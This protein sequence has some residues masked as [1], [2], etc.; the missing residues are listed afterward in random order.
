MKKFLA[1]LILCVSCTFAI[2]IIPVYAEDGITVNYEGSTVSFDAEPFLENGITMI[3]MRA[4]AEKMGAEV[5]WSPSTKITTIKRGQD[6]LEIPVGGT[7]AK[8]NGQDILLDMPAKVVN[9]RVF[10]PLR[11]VGEQLG[12]NVVWDKETKIIALTEKAEV[13]KKSTTTQYTSKNKN[14]SIILPS[15]NW[16]EEYSDLENTIIAD[17]TEGELS[18]LISSFDKQELKLSGIQTAE[19]FAKFN[20]DS[21]YYTV[22]AMGKVIEQHITLNNMNVVTADEI[23]VEE[24][25]TISKAFF[26][27]GE[28]E[29]S[30]YVCAITGEQE[31]YDKYISS[32]KSALQTIK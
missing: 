15:E 16:K 9:G 21:A 32:L 14:Y 13:S 24:N 27:Y 22:Y 4:I 6:T 12:L 25:D 10:V 1:T 20:K 23:I 30:Y 31:L 3:P 11:F 7:I 2:S 5:L 29:D 19:E 8:K 18:V 28:T 17:S 26:V